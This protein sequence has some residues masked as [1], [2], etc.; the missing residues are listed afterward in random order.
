[1]GLELKVRF[2]WIRER[3]Q[4]GGRWDRCG[5]CCENDSTLKWVVQCRQISVPERDGTLYILY[6]EGRF[7]EQRPPEA[8]SSAAVALSPGLNAYYA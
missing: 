3:E 8:Q 1:M 5:R 2:D 4:H 7:G 6:S